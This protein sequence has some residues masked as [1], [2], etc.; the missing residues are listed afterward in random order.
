MNTTFCP[1]KQKHVIM[2][3]DKIIYWTA[4]GLVAAGMG[5]SAFMYLSSNPE[6]LKIL[7]Q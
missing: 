1:V 4:T 3:R 5:M 7:K 6:L 2:K